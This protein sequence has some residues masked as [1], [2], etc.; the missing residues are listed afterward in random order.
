MPSSD[1]THRSAEP[2]ENEPSARQRLDKWLWFARVVKTRSAAAKLICQGHVRVNSRR[3]ATPAKPVSPGDV[4]TI[5]LERQVR[6]LK[7]LATGLR[8]GP[9]VQARRLFEDL[10][11]G[12][13]P[14]APPS[15]AGKSEGE[16]EGARKGRA[17]PQGLARRLPAAVRP[18][19]EPVR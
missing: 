4:L 5:A 11:S 15:A 12:L 7:I 16:G 6:V 1:R 17:D 13:G 10:S 14:N 2:A 8:R 3:I 18:N 9:A 19:S